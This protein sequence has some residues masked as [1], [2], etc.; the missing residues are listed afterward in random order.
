M[1]TE[2]FWVFH[3]LQSFH[4]VQTVFWYCDRKG[5]FYTFSLEPF[6]E[7]NSCKS[8]KDPFKEISLGA[9]EIC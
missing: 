9:F 6:I 3:Y 4:Y 8:I 2:I 1:K 5:D 7:A